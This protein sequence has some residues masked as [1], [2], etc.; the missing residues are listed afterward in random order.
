MTRPL[1]ARDSVAP[2][3]HGPL[4]PPRGDFSHQPVTPVIRALASEA[5]RP[6]VTP[7]TTPLSF[8][9]LIAVKSRTWSAVRRR[10]HL[11]HIMLYVAH[12]NYT[13]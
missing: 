3:P 4:R 8:V 12:I 5:S 2:S 1:E 7:V 6:P 13:G 9:R 10:R 11:A